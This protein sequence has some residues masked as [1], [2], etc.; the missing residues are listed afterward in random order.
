MKI[1][2]SLP[3]KW[4]AKVTIIQEAK[5][6]TKLPLEN[7][8]RSLMTHEITMKSHRDVEE[9]KKKSITLKIIT[10]EKEFEETENESRK[11]ENLALIKMKFRK[12]M[13]GEK[14]KGRIFIFRK[15]SQKKETSSN[16]DK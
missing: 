9:K 11:D 13:K 2:R 10:H 15:V 14:F 8:I 4:E 6:L 1:L 7:L 5:D 3:K 12:F 16:G